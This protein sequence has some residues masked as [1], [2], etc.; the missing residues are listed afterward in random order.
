MSFSNEVRQECAPDWDACVDHR[1]VWEILAGT[2]PPE[3]MRRYLT[4]DYQFIDGFVALLGMAIATADQFESRIRFAQHRS[5]LLGF[6]SINEA[7]GGLAL[8][9]PGQQVRRRI[10]LRLGG[11]TLGDDGADVREFSFREQLPHTGDV[12]ILIAGRT[13]QVLGW[14]PVGVQRPQP[15][16]FGIQ[17]LAVALRREEAKG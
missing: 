13:E 9:E 2:V 14:L 17:P 3:M 7:A 11:L 15:G 10:P 6:R 8:I 5:P 4:Q 1:F 16:R 12:G